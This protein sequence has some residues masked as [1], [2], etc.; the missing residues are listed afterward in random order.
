MLSIYHKLAVKFDIT[1]EKAEKLFLSDDSQ[2]LESESIDPANVF[3]ELLLQI[4]NKIEE[5]PQFDKPENVFLSGGVFTRWLMVS[6]AQKFFGAHAQVLDPFQNS[7]Q[8]QGNN[9]A[10]FNA[11][12]GLFIR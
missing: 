9:G 4:Q 11:A 5:Q 6:V 12:Y 10:E 7:D 2:L 8:F 1:L 3:A